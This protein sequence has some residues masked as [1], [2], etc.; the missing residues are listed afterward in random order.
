MSKGKRIQVYEVDSGRGTYWEA[1]PTVE[2]IWD[3][4]T[5]PHGII[6]SPFPRSVD[7]VVADRIMRMCRAGYMVTVTTQEAVH[8]N[9]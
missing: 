2:G 9:D 3:C 5:I 8:L 1:W 6:E 7:M 4:D